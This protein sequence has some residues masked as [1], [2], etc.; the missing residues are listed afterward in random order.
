M[1]SFPQRNIQE[2]GV[3]LCHLKFCKYTLGVSK[4]DANVGIYGDTGRIPIAFNAATFFMKYWYRVA[5]VTKEENALLYSAYCENK[6]N[7]KLSMGWYSNVKYM[8]NM[9][10]EEVDMESEP[11]NCNYFVRK[12]Q[13]TL[14]KE[15]VNGWKQEL[16]DD[17][18][19]KQY[20]NKL[21]SYRKFKSEFGIEDYLFKCTNVNSRKRLSRFRLSSHNLRIETDRYVTPRIPPELRT[22]KYCDL[23]KTEDEIHF[24]IEC[25]KYDELRQT[26]FRN[27]NTK[28]AYFADMQKELQFIWLLG[29]KE[30]EIINSLGHFLN[31]CFKLREN[32]LN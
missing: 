7:N 16:F 3:K 6:L 4:R 27:I 25:K 17:R 26:F 13:A 32:G 24:V 20:G 12:L 29:H 23:D 2:N 14:K 15:F 18:C 5:N 10:A 28:Y 9:I 19:N 1:L 21:R 8:L 22:C 31:E 11:K 30:Y